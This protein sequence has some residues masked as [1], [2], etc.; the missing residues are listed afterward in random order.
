MTER[1]RW[2]GHVAR[3]VGEN[4]YAQNASERTYVSTWTRIGDDIKMGINER[5]YNGVIELTRFALVTGSGL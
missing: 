4:K 5:V 1:V 2:T 3:K